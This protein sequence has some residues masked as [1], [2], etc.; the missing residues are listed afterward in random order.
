[1]LEDLEPP[2]NSRTCKIR[3]ILADLDEKDRAIL[4]D[5]LT[6]QMRWS[7]NALAQALRQRGIFV[8]VHPILSHRKGI[9]RCSTI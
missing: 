8:S 7:A 1:M 4:E 5:A 3:R 6:D 9:C 2:G